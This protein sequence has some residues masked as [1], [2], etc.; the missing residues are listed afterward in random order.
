LI[1][2]YENENQVAIKISHGI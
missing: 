2:K 1:K